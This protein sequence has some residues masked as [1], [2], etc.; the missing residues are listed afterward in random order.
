[1]ARSRTGSPRGAK[2]RLCGSVV[3]WYPLAMS[4]RVVTHEV[5]ARSRSR[6]ASTASSGLLPAKG[7]QPDER[8]DVPVARLI[9]DLVVLAG[10]PAT[11]E[12]LAADA[13]EPAGLII[14]DRA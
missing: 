4:G 14:E 8:D 11:E 6:N 13:H 1:M 9:G 10:L 5:T 3:A 12:L 2:L 7:D